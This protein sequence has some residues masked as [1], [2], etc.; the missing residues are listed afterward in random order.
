[1]IKTKE[2]NLSMY[3]F[4]V[5]SNNIEVVMGY[6]VEEVFVEA[7]R[8]NPEAKTIRMTK[9]LDY[10]EVARSVIN[11]Y[12]EQQDIKDKEDKD[13]PVNKTDEFIE[14][15]EKNEEETINF[16]KTIR[17]VYGNKY[18][19]NIIKI[20]GTGDGSTKKQQSRP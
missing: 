18:I 12:G 2:K 15:K 16:L 17:D 8:L 9:S 6:D 14:K 4:L 7:K 10:N 3:L 5:D 1:M 11:F 19:G 20:I 13:Y